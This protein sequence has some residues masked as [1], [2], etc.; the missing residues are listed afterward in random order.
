VVL[1]AEDEPGVRAL[2][3]RVLGKLGYTVL[4]ASDGDAALRFIKGYS[5]RSIDLLLTDVVMP[6]PARP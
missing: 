3:S 4:E 2:V 6:R 1:L 5:G